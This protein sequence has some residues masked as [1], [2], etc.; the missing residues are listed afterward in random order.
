M[1]LVLGLT[2]GIATG[3]STADK[4]FQKKQIPIIDCDLLA[5]QLMEPGEVLWQEIKDVFGPAYLKADHSIDRKKLGQLVFNNPQEL[6]RLNQLT[7]KWIY[8]KIQERIAAA[9]KAQV[10]LIVVDAPTLYESGGQEYCDQV[11]VIALPAELQLK[12][13]MARNN[14]SQ[15][16]ALA[17]INSQ[18]PLTKKIAQANYVVFNT[19][20]IEELKSKLEEVLLKIEAE[21]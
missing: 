3:K 14:L 8:R 15:D 21:V 5:H 12:R 4:F 17:R 16:Q 2:G 7:H 20:T 1:T 9:K 10:P 19:G 6:A 11:L 18:M 13:L